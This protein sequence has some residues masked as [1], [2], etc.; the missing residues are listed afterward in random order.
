MILTACEAKPEAEVPTATLTPTRTAI[1]TTAL[2]TPR[3]TAKM[4]PESTTV[5]LVPE[6]RSIGAENI[7]RYT[8]TSFVNDIAFDKEGMMWVATD[9]GVMRWNLSDDS[10][11]K[12]TSEDGL[13]GNSIDSMLVAADGSVW[14]ETYEGLLYYDGSGWVM[15]SGDYGSLIGL[16]SEGNLWTFDYG[17]LYYF[18]DNQWNEVN[19]GEE[20][21][22]WMIYDA[23]IDQDGTIWADAENELWSFNG[24]TWTLH[25]A[26]SGFDGS[27]LYVLTIGPDGNFQVVASEGLYTWDST[28]WSITPL[29]VE[30]PDGY[31]LAIHFTE[32]GVLWVSYVSYESPDD[33]GVY[34]FDGGEWEKYF[35]YDPEGTLTVTAIRTAPDGTLV[36]GTIAGVLHLE[37]DGVWHLH[38]TAEEPISNTIYGLYKDRDGVIWMATDSGISRVDGSSWEHFRPATSSYG[39]TVSYA[40][41]FA[42]TLDG[43]L[44]SIGGTGIFSFS[45]GEW[46]MTI[47][48]PEITI[49][50]SLPPPLFDNIYIDDLAVSSSGEVWTCGYYYG[51]S[52]QGMGAFRYDGENWHHYT[53]EDWLG[54]LLDLDAE[55]IETGVLP[56]DF[57]NAVAEGPNGGMWLGAYE[58]GAARFEDEEWTILSGPEYFPGDTISGIAKGLD[59]S[60]WFAT[61]NGFSHFDGYDWTVYDL[62]G[63]PADYGSGMITVDADGVV[64]YAS[65]ETGL[66]S[67]DGNTFTVYEV[68]GVPFEGLWGSDLVVGEDG[69][70]WLSDYQ[71]VMSIHVGETTAVESSSDRAVIS[72]EKIHHITSTSNIH[73]IVFDQEGLMWV[74]SD[75]GAVRW[76]LTDGSYTK[77]TS[78]DGLAGID[79][80]DLEVAPGGTVWAGSSG[81][82]SS[83]DGTGWTQS[84]FGERTLIGIGPNG[85]MWSRREISLA[86]HDGEQWVE[87]NSEGQERPYE[88][89]IQATGP[90]GTIW[91]GY[92][93]ELWS[94]DGEDWTQHTLDDYEVG[95]LKYFRFSPEGD[96]WTVANE[97]IFRFDGKKWED[98]SVPVV[99]ER[100][101]IIE[102]LVLE[103]GVLMA[104]FVSDDTLDSTGVYRYDGSGWERWTHLDHLTNL[105]VKKMISVPDGAIVLGTNEGVFRV[106]GETIEHYLVPNEPAGN[107][108]NALH[109][110]QDGS[111]WIAT[112]N[113]L[114]RFDGEQWESFRPYSPMSTG[115]VYSYSTSSVLGLT[116]SGD[117]EL[118]CLGSRS[119][120]AFTDN[121]WEWLMD[122]PTL[123]ELPFTEPTIFPKLGNL[124]SLD[125]NREGELWIT[126]RLQGV[127]RYD[128]T[129]WYNYSAID[130]SLYE[131][132]EEFIQTGVLPNNTIKSIVDGPDG[133]LWLAASVGTTIL[134]GGVVRFDGENWREVNGREGFLGNALFDMAKGLDGSL[135]FAGEKGFANY[136]GERWSFY[137]RGVNYPDLADGYLAV[138]P[139]GLVWFY[140]PE[141][142]LTSFDSEVFTDYHLELGNSTNAWVLWQILVDQE[143][144]VWLG[145]P[146]EGLYAIHPG[147]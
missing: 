16:D 54:E 10:Y 94:F 81:G 27:Y 140:S 78:E 64:W 74:A 29:P 49:D 131:L 62:G 117:G 50:P 82:L 98:H 111:L 23:K 20:D 13:G 36:F 9:G 71:G 87:V 67:F 51:E 107:S 18:D 41:D 106:E 85:Y 136:D 138:G 139:Q 61:Q 125:A 145:S 26:D 8:S 102:L 116:E 7:Q 130:V 47:E 1:P 59:G 35:G 66:S 17:G 108:I 128:G 68:E 76:N 70:L 11:T 30:F 127:L 84:S 56:N 60:L 123:P 89:H 75:G 115:S 63:D 33:T 105:L 52:G 133:V 48:S 101:D 19:E 88:I 144:M 12:F 21:S 114:S 132:G 80:D 5:R 55:L 32:E 34:V 142:G 104:S 31:Y 2:P 3:P 73:D 39:P 124:Q 120:Y 93:D 129:D 40:H 57:I 113:G 91:F 72:A 65:G 28:G 96:L 119:I 92:Y 44:L 43:K 147:E 69:T 4:P 134:E 15:E 37:E 6:Y 46:E 143:G 110:D 109:L 146:G 126:D 118:F 22:P 99:G 79:L 86:Y 112:D 137:E 135:W 14:V 141:T 121:Q 45:D 38:Q 97:G 103:N 83:F 95:S 58:G 122:I 77:F 42:E 90:D 24:N 25:T 53:F 100:G